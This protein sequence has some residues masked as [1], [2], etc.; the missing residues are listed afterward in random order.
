MHVVNLL[1]KM[2]CFILLQNE[3]EKYGPIYDCILFLYSS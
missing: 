3:L 2:A 1:F